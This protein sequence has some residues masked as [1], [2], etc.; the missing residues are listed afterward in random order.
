MSAEIGKVRGTTEEV[1]DLK[2]YM[3]KSKAD[4]ENLQEMIKENQ[5]MQDFLHQH[6]FLVPE[7]DFTL[8]VRAYE[9]P[10]KMLDIMKEAVAK[11]NKEHRAFEYALKK[12]RAAFSQLLMKYE[13][14]I[15]QFKEWKEI[16]RPTDYSSAA[17]DMSKRLGQAQ[18]EAEE[19]N[20]LERL[21]GW[22][23]TKFEKVTNLN[24]MLS[25]FLIL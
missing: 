15:E 18:E 25:P 7:S 21:F 9:W 12:R 22:P 8:A 17:E 4:Q 1:L 14:E 16:V 6:M 24:N 23:A 5:E 19:I 10:K 2:A 3:Q 20:R 13:E 11:L